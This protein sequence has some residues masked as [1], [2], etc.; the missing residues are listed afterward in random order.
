MLTPERDRRYKTGAFRPE[1]GR[2]GR[3]GP[4]FYPGQKRRRFVSEFSLERA[5]PAV[6]TGTERDQ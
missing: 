5:I 3:I 4:E 1:F 2:N 6:L